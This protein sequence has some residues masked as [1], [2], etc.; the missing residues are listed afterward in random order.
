M[1]IYTIIDDAG[2]DKNIDKD[3]AICKEG[4]LRLFGNRLISL[5]L[6]GGYG[7]GEGGLARSG[8]SFLPKNNYDFLVV[9]KTAPFWEKRKME[10]ALE[11]LK[12]ELDAKLLALF[13]CR[14]RSDSQVRRSPNVMIF[15]DIYNSS[16]TVYGEDIRRLLPPRVAELLPP[17]ESLRIIKNR[18]MLLL[19]AILKIEHQNYKLTPRQVKIW[20]SKAIIGFGD[21][22]LIL[23]KEYVTK[24]YEKM[25]AIKRLDFQD[26]FVETTDYQY[27]K[28]LHEAASLYRLKDEDSDL[29][30]DF[31]KGIKVLEQVNLWAL[32]EYTKDA[33]FNWG[34]L[35]NISLYAK[36]PLPRALKNI[37]INI[38]KYGVFQ[39]LR[40]IMISPSDRL[41]K[42][43]P[44]LLYRPNFDF[45]KICRVEMHMNKEATLDDIQR[46]CFN[47]YAEN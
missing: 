42:V 21:A 8:G 31:D 12:K 46:E 20:F 11:G 29:L 45:L 30:K 26:A 17:I 39:N 22:I 47:V 16:K 35:A 36:E 2:L 32:R 23:K 44:L 6:I 41:L 27:F 43:V 40:D 5:V 9:L 7:Q 24:Y 18:S 19:A 10:R 34:K 14:L 13:E 28:R 38:K 4:A 33:G 37:A 1:G 15:H 25:I 3:I